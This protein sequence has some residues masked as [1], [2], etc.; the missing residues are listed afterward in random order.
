[1]QQ[2]TVYRV[3]EVA[4]LL[5]QAEY[6]SSFVGRLRGLL[7]KTALSLKQ[8]LLLAPCNQIHTVGMGFAIDVVFLAKDGMVLRC[9]EKLRPHRFARCRSAYQ[10][11][12]LMAGAVEHYALQ[13]GECLHWQITPNKPEKIYGQ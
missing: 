2:L 5:L 12:E 4:P 9:V 7:G 11:L 3:G 6:A 13:E 10:T 8:G 1:M